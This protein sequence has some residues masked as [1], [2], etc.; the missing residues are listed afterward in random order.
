MEQ[1]P[2]TLSDVI[3]LIQ[4]VLHEHYGVD[5]NPLLESVGIDPARADVS[6]SRVLRESVMRLWEVAAAH[7]GDPSIGLLVGSKVR[8]TTFHALGMAF[9]TCENLRDSLELLC[10]YY[11]VIVT[12]PMELELKDKGK[13]TVLEI[14][15]TDPDFPL[16][17]IPFDS[18]IAS[19]VAFCRLAKTPDF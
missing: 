17:P 7:T 1:Q 16:L 11:K 5:P 13:Q 8:A 18:F 19:I 10:R 3:R 2:T 4:E 12:V 6:G 14:T 9:M 15:Y